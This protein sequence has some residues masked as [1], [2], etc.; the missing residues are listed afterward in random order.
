LFIGLTVG[1]AVVLVDVLYGFLW[2]FSES[3]ISR[4][5]F[6]PLLFGC[7]ALPSGLLVV[8][9][10][11]GEKAGGCGTHRLIEAYN[12]GDGFLGFRESLGRA[13]ASAVTIGLGGSAGMEGPSL[14][15]GGGVASSLYGLSRLKGEERRV[16]AL[17]GAAAG[18][19][20]IFRAPLTGILFALEI[21]FQRDL[22]KEAF[23]PAT[24][25]SV[26]AYFVS[27]SFLGGERVFPAISGS[28]TL[29]LGILAHSVV[30]GV[31]AGFAARFFVWFYEWLGRFRL[32]SFPTPLIG[33]ALLGLV[34]MFAPHV[35]GL[36]YDS[37]HAVLSGEAESWSV[38]FM[39][40]LLFLKVFA[41]SATLNMGGSGGLFVPSLFIGAMLGAAYSRI[42][43][44]ADNAVL[45]MCGMAGVVAAGNK[46]L[47][48]S[49]ALVAETAG[50]SSVMASLI[51]ATVAYHVSGNTSFYRD[52]QPVRELGEEKTLFQILRREDLSGKFLNKT[53]VKNVMSREACLIGGERSIRE[54]FEI[55]RKNAS[56][57]CIVVDDAGIVLGE[58]RLE[59]VLTVPEE[60]WNLPVRYASLKKPLTIN[61]DFSLRE[62]LDKMI[63]TGEN[64]ALVVDV[65]GKFIGYISLPLLMNKLV[66]LL[67]K[68]K[69]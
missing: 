23:I 60:K 53:L 31:L 22:V 68:L 38:P 19:S 39:L 48:A 1:L 49:V 8:R 21:P 47:L 65:S 36:G 64:H 35:L 18:L 11:A 17:A 52:V 15:L 26:V 27:V 51:T 66:G 33:G 25:S 62:L 13:L 69:S 24:F 67:D 40:L 57:A 58:L 12:F 55:L 41:T 7:L 9:V 45:V 61:G 14:L 30:L 44:R 28:V 56:R 16:Y 63:E 20:A 54:A 5:G 37:I 43:L 2:G 42:A 6:W 32:E 46:T 3:F 34:G 10:V 4:G 29:S 59:D 50:T